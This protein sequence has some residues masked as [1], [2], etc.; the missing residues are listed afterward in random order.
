MPFVKEKPWIL[1]QRT[2]LLCLLIA[3]LPL[4]SP[5]RAQQ[6]IGPVA[7]WK[8]DEGQGNK[9]YDSAGGYSDP[10][11]N[12]FDWAK[13]VSGDGLKFD[14]FTTVVER[15]AADAPKL[16]G[17][18]TIDAWVALHSYPWNWV[19]IVDQDKNREAGYYFGVDAEGRLGLQLEVWGVWEVCRSEVRIPL[20]HWTHVTGVYTPQSGIHLYIDGKPEGMLPVTGNFTPA[21]DTP[22]WIGRNLRNLPPVALVRPWASYPALYS[23]DG[24]LDDLQI[25]NRSLSAQE[26]AAAYK[27][28][29]AAIAPALI[30]RHWPDMPGQTTHLKAA[31]TSLKL[32]PQWDRLW[33][34]GRYSDVVVSFGRLPV[35]Y[36]FWRGANYGP[37][38]VTENGIWMSD[39]SFESH[40][41]FSTAEHMND[42]HDMHSSISI[43]EDTPARVVLRWR[44]ALVDVL[45][46]FADVDPCTGW[47][48]WADEYFYIYPDGVAVR[49]GTI[50]GTKGHYSFTEPT[51][52]LAPG[53]K[54]EDFISLRAATI[55][56]SA[57]DSRT[58]SW[59]PISPP[60]PFSNQPPGANIALINLK[61]HYK[62][63]YIYRP[64]TRLGPYGWPPEL[65]PLYS[66]FPVWNHWPV[67]Q[68]P[69]DGRFAL[70]ADHF[71]SAAIMSPD[72][73]ATWIGGP[74]PTKTTY[75]LFGLTDGGIQDLAR[76]DRSWLHPPAIRI[77]DGD[78][79][80]YHPGQKAYLISLA[81]K[82]PRLE[83][84]L[85]TMG[86]SKGSPMVN[87]AFVIRNWGSST[88]RISI[89]GTRLPGDEYRIGHRY[90]LQGTDLILWLD[91]TSEQPT[92]ISII[93]RH[94]KQSR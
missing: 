3:V 46:N 70:F 88:P 85:M 84:V 10:I 42:K 57:G 48:D 39:Q 16:R 78:T 79:A 72:P 91:R 9:V 29:L 90:T 18:L 89:D 80:V 1:L 26:V 6:A 11:L 59:A 36:V 51:L 25:Y 20:D 58:Y 19:A 74:G 44:Y 7:W 64:G 35:H 75:F 27:P 5:L 52:L 17:G 77:S 73:N 14:G 13:G 86:A 4:V 24:I 54:P 76:L 93:P 56:N 8:F 12:Y 21:A 53:T 40:T 33:R 43:I 38:M 22:L 45:G 65:R 47:G 31:Y 34:T 66:H 82:E 61:S 49:H 67:N 94:Q 32:Y 41:K 71:G 63:F 50:H 69:S 92:K 30:P 62:P 68:I 28:S 23:L 15:S 37:N 81:P 83:K 55:A 87:P 2:K 60:Y